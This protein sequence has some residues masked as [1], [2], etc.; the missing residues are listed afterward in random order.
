MLTIKA[1]YRK[2]EKK[3]GMER[4]GEER[5]EEVKLKMVF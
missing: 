3:N 2:S 1:V 5:K 4:K